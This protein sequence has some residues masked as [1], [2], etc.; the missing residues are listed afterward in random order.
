M[1]LTK[2]TERRVL[3]LQPTNAEVSTNQV[4]AARYEWPI[5]GELT[6]PAP[7]IIDSLRHTDAAFSIYRIDV[8]VEQGGTSQYQITIKSY[9]TAGL[10]P[11]THVDDYI[12]ITGDKNRISIPVLNAAVPQNS[13]LELTVFESSV[14]TPASDMTVTLIAEDFASIRPERL[15]HRIVNSA[16]T[17]MAQE[18]DLK[19][20]GATLSDDPTVKTVVRNDVDYSKVRT[21]TS[22]SSATLADSTFILDC[23]SGAVTL[24]LPSAASAIDKEYSIKKSDSSVNSALIDADSTELIDEAQ[25]FQLLKQNQ[26][27]TLVS[28]GTKWQIK[29]GQIV[30]Y[31]EK[32]LTANTTAN[33]SVLT[34]LTFNNL[35]VGRTY[36]LYT[37]WVAKTGDAGEYNLIVTHNAATLD[38]V[39][40][41]G[42][43]GSA[44][45]GGAFGS[46]IIFVATGTTLTF[47]PSGA[48]AGRLGYGGAGQT[49]VL[50]EELNT[51]QAVTDW[52]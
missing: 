21:V 25:T 51:H 23:T 36:R 9:D 50:L 49:K 46:Q 10:N 28:D 52:T 26:S 33:G 4:Y 38:T 11:V 22:S 16:D 8:S 48:N 18:P 15:G 45:C 34:D 43:S 30:K 24:T 1:S 14:G 3:I 31:Q 6:F 7:T 2:Q 27:V 17:V 41:R 42:E 44:G 39:K 32:I 35:V 5:N 29:S 12:T 40:C 13:S 19:F 37:K 20:I 47:T